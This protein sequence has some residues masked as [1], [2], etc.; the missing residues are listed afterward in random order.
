MNQG[1]GESSLPELLFH[2]DLE[3]QSSDSQT[4]VFKIMFT[5]PVSVQQL[6]IVR[7]GNVPHLGMKESLTQRGEE[8]EKFEVFA[9]K[10]DENRGFILLS[11]SDKISEKGNHDTVIPIDPNYTVSFRNFRFPLIFS[12]SGVALRR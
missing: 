11:T 4:V 12:L 7:G 6:R 9:R 1:S 10:Y 5:K 8:I 3:R 2:G